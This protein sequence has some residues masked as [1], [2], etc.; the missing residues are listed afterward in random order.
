MTNSVL[1]NAS[2]FEILFFASALLGLRFSVPS[3]RLAW[4][5]FRS[6]GGISNGRRAIA[7][8]AIAVETIF[9]G[10]HALYVVA[11]VIAF[12]IPA[13]RDPTVAG[14]IIQTILV[15][16]SWGITACSWIIRR[17]GTYLL[18]HGLQSRDG[19]GR[20]TKA[21]ET[22]QQAEDRVMGE[23][24]SELPSIKRLDK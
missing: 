8:E 12:T 17:T 15:L 10:I 4:R 2:P 1:F 23:H 22:E 11:S 24:R 16:A 6:L 5:Q 21:P 14:Y 13:S 19:L 3:Y 20:F 18:E 7:V 9:I